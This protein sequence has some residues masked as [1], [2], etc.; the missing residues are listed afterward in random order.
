MDLKKIFLLIGL[1]YVVYYVIQ[2]GLEVLKQVAPKKSKDKSTVINLAAE[3]TTK[4][5]SNKSSKPVKLP[6]KMEKTIGVDVEN[7]IG[8]QYIEDNALVGDLDIDISEPPTIQVD[9]YLKSLSK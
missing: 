5:Q 1:A 2:I 8:I 6:S 9:E 7:M 4:E 3:K